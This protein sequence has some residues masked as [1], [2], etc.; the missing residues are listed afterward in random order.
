MVHDPVA[1]WNERVKLF[2]GFVS[3][4]GLGVF[5]FGVLRPL[6]ED[7]SSLSL[8]TIWWIL[9]GL[10]LHGSSHYVLRYMRKVPT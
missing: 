1:E 10:V 3:A 9:V 7:L 4:L 6:T 2:A 5:G 8:L